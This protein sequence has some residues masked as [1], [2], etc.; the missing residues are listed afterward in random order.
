M[1]HT[2]VPAIIILLYVDVNRG[3]FLQAIELFNNLTCVQWKLNSTEV[4]QEVGHKGYVRVRR[5]GFFVCLFLLNCYRLNYSIK[6][7]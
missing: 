4:Q 1:F 5:S 6:W 7:S 2:L 3:Y